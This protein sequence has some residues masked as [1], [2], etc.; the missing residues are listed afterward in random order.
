MS[1]CSDCHSSNC[2]TG[3]NISIN[4][5]PKGEQI[6]TTVKREDIPKPKT[7]P[8]PLPWAAITLSVVVTLTLKTFLDVKIHVRPEID[9]NFSV[10]V[11]PASPSPQ[12]PTHPPQPV[13]PAPK[14]PDY[15]PSNPQ[16]PPSQSP[17]ESP[18]SPPPN[19]CTQT[20]I[21]HCK[22]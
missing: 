18:E 5:L 8:D 10:E 9:G 2:N 14:L 6:V 7:C 1:E 19:I 12:P 13:E 22:W 3:P 21:L 17:A 11:H 4:D 15:Y 16:Y 20:E